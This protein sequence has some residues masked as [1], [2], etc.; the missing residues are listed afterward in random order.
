MALGRSCACAKSCAKYALVQLCVP[1]C[2]ISALILFFVLFQQSRIGNFQS[3]RCMKFHGI[4][5]SKSFESDSAGSLNFHGGL[6]QWVAVSV[7]AAARCDCCCSTRIP[8]R[9]VTGRKCLWQTCNIL[10][11]FLQDLQIGSQMQKL[12]PDLHYVVTWSEEV[13]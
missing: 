5:E 8:K 9:F 11:D 7:S 2:E 1:R 10:W 13:S 6:G 3:L 4:F 12:D